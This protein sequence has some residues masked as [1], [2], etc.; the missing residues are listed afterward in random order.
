MVSAG[1]KLGQIIGDWYEEYFALPLLSRIAG[2]LNLFVDSRFA[3]RSCRGEK[4]LW[5]D[6]DGN[7]VDYDFVMEIGGAPD[8]LGTPVAFFETFWRRGSRH[9]KDKARDDSGKLLPMKNTYPAARVLCIV[10]AGDFTSP[11][12]EFVLSKGVELFYVPK[13]HILN[14]WQAHG[15]TVDYP[16]KSS[17]DMKRKLV[18]HA[19]SIIAKNDNI[20]VDVADTLKTLVGKSQLAAFEKRIASRLGATPQEYKITVHQSSDPFSFYSHTAVYDFLGDT[21]SLPELPHT[22]YSYEVVFGDGDA[23]WGEAL[24]LEE[25]KMRHAE[26]KKLIIHMENIA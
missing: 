15:V 12:R 8:R 14:A 10:S 23:F 24:S 18:E 20:F 13:I 17:E 9:S 16:D 21:I 19:E 3:E 1:H 5:K 22:N 2:Q 7:A 25:L 6:D 11:A 4:I 26:L